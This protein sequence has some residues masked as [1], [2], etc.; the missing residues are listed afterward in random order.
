MGRQ[1]WLHGPG[2]MPLGRAALGVYIDCRLGQGVSG[3]IGGWKLLTWVRDYSFFTFH[4]TVGLILLGTYETQVT[5]YVKFH[6][7]YI[8]VA[9]KRAVIVAG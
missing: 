1:G 5:K 7:F 9:L 2:L 3:G 6:C 8:W 4:F